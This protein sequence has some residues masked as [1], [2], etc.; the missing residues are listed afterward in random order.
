[1]NSAFDNLEEGIF[2]TSFTTSPHVGHTSESA[3]TF[4]QPQYERPFY[5]YFDQHGMLMKVQSSPNCG[6]W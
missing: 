5:Y 6:F 3:L 4:S 1:M 2:C